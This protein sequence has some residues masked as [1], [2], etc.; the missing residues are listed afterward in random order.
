[1]V[2]GNIESQLAQTLFAQREND[3]SHLPYDDELSFY[4]AVKRGDLELVKKTMLPLSNQRL[5]RL[6]DNGLRNMQYH[7][8]IT[9]AFITRFCIEGG[10]DPEL[11][12]TLSDLNIQRIDKCQSCEEVKSLHEEMV[13][14]IAMRMHH[15]QQKRAG[16]PKILACKDYIS[17]HLHESFSI[18]ELASKAGLSASYLCA[19]FKKETNM[20]IAQYVRHQRIEAA[21]NLLQYSET[22]YSDLGHYLAFSSHSHFISIFKKEV[23]MTPKEFRNK[24][25]RQKWTK[26]EHI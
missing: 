17:H 14:D 22:A 19:L 24:Y 25:Y 2:N 4:N 16:S 10:V 23:G 20:T 7:L 11:A 9:I 5:G 18:K 12:Y 15:L 21:K 8:I 6:S 1:M 3:F 13:L 26:P